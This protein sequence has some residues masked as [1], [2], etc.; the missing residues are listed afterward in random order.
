MPINTGQVFGFSGLDIRGERGAT[1]AAYV[2]ALQAKGLS[3]LEIGE[4][5][6]A[7][8]TSLMLA[9]DPSLVR[10]DRLRD[11]AGADHEVTEPF[12]GFALGGVG[13]K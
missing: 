5:A 6:G 1:V 3:D 9:I 2:R 7:A 8:D 11:E 12:P 13:G 4:H 10:S